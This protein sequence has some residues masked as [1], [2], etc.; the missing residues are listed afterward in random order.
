MNPEPLLVLQSGQQIGPFPHEAVRDMLRAGTLSLQDMAWQAGMPE[1]LP[2]EALFPDLATE[3][4]AASKTTDPGPAPVQFAL[5]AERSFTAFAPDAF[6]YPFRGDG[7]I[8]L[9]GGTVLFSVLGAVPAVGIYGTITAIAL[10]GYLLLMLQSVVQ[11]TA[12]GEEVLPRW[13]GFTGFAELFEIW[14]QW[15][16]VLAV[17][18]GPAY[19]V[20]LSAT[21]ESALRPE[22]NWPVIV[23]LAVVGGLYFPMAVLGVAMFDSVSALNPRLVL[24]SIFAAPGHYLLLLA[25][26][27]GLMTVQALTGRLSDHVPFVGTLVDNFDRLWSAVVFARLI[28]GLYYVN[29]RKLGWF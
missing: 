25:T 10:W 19:G 12:Q 14:S 23:G 8:I 5:P 2:L 15:F 22:F 21:A 18:F 7:V 20:Y 9:L 28:G 26:L 29:R 27:T 16:V 6:G 3:V 13:P 11:G 17:C 4:M 24:R 1:W